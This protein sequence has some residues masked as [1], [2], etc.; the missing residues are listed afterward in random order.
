MDPILFIRSHFPVGHSD[1]GPIHILVRSLRSMRRCDLSHNLSHRSDIH[2]ATSSRL[3]TLQSV[4]SLIAGPHWEL[5]WNRNV[6][7]SHSG[8]TPKKSRLGY[9]QIWDSHLGD[10]QDRRFGHYHIS[11]LLH[12]IFL[13]AQPLK[14]EDLLSCLSYNRW[15]S[16][17]LLLL[18]AWCLP[19]VPALTP[20]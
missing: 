14:E 1:R 8:L 18:S 2:Q 19:D 16:E 11:L 9:R 7:I 12:C 5:A 3:A 6:P 20:P 15:I 13:A 17:N 10:V 4:S